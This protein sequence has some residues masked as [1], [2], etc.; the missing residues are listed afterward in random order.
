MYSVVDIKNLQRL[1]AS[2]RRVALVACGRGRSLRDLQRVNTL[3]EEAPV[4]QRITFLPVFYNVLDPSQIPTSEDLESLNSDATE[5]MLC[6]FASLPILFGLTMDL[7]FDDL[8][9]TLWARIWPWIYFFENY[10]EYFPA[11]MGLADMPIHR[12]SLL[13]IRRKV[14]FVY[15]LAHFIGSASL[16]EPRHFQ[17]IIDGAGGTVGDL[18]F[19]ATTYL[20]AVLDQGLPRDLAYHIRCLVRFILFSGCGDPES[21]LHPKFMET[22]SQ[23]DFAGSAVVAINFLLEAPSSNDVLTACRETFELVELVAGRHLGAMSR[24]SILFGPA[25]DGSLRY[26][27]ASTLPGSLL[28]Y[29]VVAATEAALEDLTQIWSSQSP[30]TTELLG[31]W[32]TFIALAER[33]IEIMRARDEFEYFKACDNLD[34]GKIRRRTLYRRCSGCK[35]FYYYNRQCQIIDWRQGG[36]RNHCS[37]Y[38]VLCPDSRERE[39]LRRAI[40]QDY[41]KEMYLVLEQHVSLTVIDSDGLFFTFF[42]YTLTPVEISVHPAITDFLSDMGTEWSDILSRVRRSG[43]RMRLHVVHVP[44]GGSDTRFWVIPLR[45]SNPHFHDAVLELA[46]DNRTSYNY[47]DVMAGLSAAYYDI[48]DIGGLREIH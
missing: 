37:S 12:P 22:L 29:H 43:G 28:Y 46:E 47:D 44:E 21:A 16:E 8:G 14:S 11:S 10:Q 40:G 24:A 39:F 6:A 25:L 1:P 48:P 33:R 34:C 15:D 17:E 30:E 41:T 26:L 13:F 38:R 27:L 5:R 20:N 35:S 3:M 4:G 2:Q 18:A 31:D 36:H 32:V 7:D 9:Y 23:H 19:L 42:D 45:A